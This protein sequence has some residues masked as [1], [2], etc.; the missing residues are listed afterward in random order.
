MA[1]RSRPYHHGNLRSTLLSCAER[2]LSEH[3]AGDLSLRELARQAGVSHAAP[4]RHFADKQ[5][6]LDALAEDGFDR[7]G[8]EL[9]EAMAAAGGAFHAR[10]LAF[11][12]TYVRFATQHAA[13]LDLMFAGKHREGA[14]DSLREAADR[15]FEAPL[16]L[17][18]EGQAAGHVVPG[19]P[20]RVAI[21]TWAA[22][23]GLASMVNSGMIADAG[24]DELVADAVDRLVAGLRPR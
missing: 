1:T 9:R 5:S 16:A 18:A 14:A 23:Q 15:A 17:I 10:L 22:L 6:L 4:R 7:L 20:E 13:L 24:L 2:T 11:A 19:D 8:G 3:G 12:Q 21:V